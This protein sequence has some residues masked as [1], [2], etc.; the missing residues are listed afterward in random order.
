[1]SD[2][3]RWQ[4][5]LMQASFIFITV[6]LSVLAVAWVLQKVLVKEALQLEASSFIEAY[7]ADPSFTLPRTRNLGGYLAHARGQGNTVPAAL[8]ALAPGLHQEVIV[9]QGERP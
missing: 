4:R 2:S 3:E 9:K 7:E 5:V 6:L 1:M 8:R